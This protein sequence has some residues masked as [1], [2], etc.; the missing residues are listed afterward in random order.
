MDSFAKAPEMIAYVPPAEAIQA[1]SVSTGTFDAELGMAGGSAV[2]VI[3]KS[4]TNTY[5]G[6]AWEYNTISKLNA[7]NFFYFGSEIPKFISNQFGAA[8][9]GPI[10][11][12]KLFFFADWERIMKRQAAYGTYSVPNAQMRQGDFSFT[13]TKIYDPLTGSSNGT[14]RAQFPG[15]VIPVS[16][17]SSAAQIMTA[18]IPQPNLPGNSSNYFSVA[19]YYAN[20]DNIDIKINYNPN[21]NA[22]IFGRYSVL[23]YTLFDATALGPAGGPGISSGDVQPGHATGTI[24][25]TSLGGS[26]VLTPAL[27]LDGVAGFTR[28]YRLSKNVDIGTNYGLDVLKIPGTNG[29][30]PLDGGYPYFNVSGWTA[31]GNSNLSSPTFERDNEYTFSGNL[32]WIKRSHSLR[33]GVDYVDFGLNS[34]QPQILWGPRGGFGFSGGLTALSGGAAANSYNAWADFMLGQAQTMGKDIQYLNPGTLRE[35][36]VGLYA[37]DQ[38]QVRNDITLTLGLRYEAYPLG[39][40]DHFGFNRYDPTTNLELLGG[41][42]GV[43]SDTGANA[44]H[45]I[46][47]PR[48]GIAYRLGEKMVIRAGYGISVDPDNFRSMLA[49][50]PLQLSQQLSGSNSY[51]AAGNLLTGLPAVALPDISSGKL[52][53]PSTLGTT[54]YP[55]NF[56]RG[57]IDSYNLTVQ[58]DLGHGFNLQA[59]YV[60]TL[61]IR[62]T[63]SININASTPNGGTAAEPLNILWHNTSTI[64]MVT[65]FNSARFNS[66]QVQA[67]KRFRGASTGRMAYTFG[68]AL[69]YGDNSAS[70]LSWNWTPL[71]SRNYALA[72][73]DRTHNLQVFGTYELP[74]GRG[75]RWLTQGW[76][77]KIAGGWQLNG[78]LSA[79]SG[80]PFTVSSSSTALNSPG[81][82]QTANQVLPTVAIYGGLTPYFNTTAFAA[83][84]GAGVFGNS[85]RNILRGPGFFNLDSSLFRNF[86]INERFKLQFRAE[87]FGTTN[88][89][90]FGNPAATVTS[91]GFGNI[92][93]STGQRQL[94][95]A[96][97]LNY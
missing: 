82:A 47:A 28:M 57:Y 55:Q 33:F 9:G 2:N 50:Y 78:I 64:S 45:G 65:P 41:L 20:K 49:A 14:G 84:T 74:F 88:T 12:N 85:G 81:N 30:L 16:R 60:G 42:G 26:Y 68:R 71:W 7:R 36:S 6:A 91:G 39:S 72:G 23:P 29:P 58:R 92:T 46:F 94:R 32:S 66:L 87:A 86:R 79:V 1:V 13:T 11:K 52:P 69:D 51:S 73:Y 89:P 95:F 34:F 62:Q 80:T 3:M 76:V 38:W 67:V 25:N 21:E 15:N 8:F 40:A 96:M 43:P 44:G 75:Q 37:R 22:S 61:S 35:K 31:L 4:G 53:F 54:T 24:T 93:S 59:G 18:L 27:L 56:R 10:K 77:N 19:D 83:T 48:V 63:A 17:L 5:H 90:H 97:K 70:S